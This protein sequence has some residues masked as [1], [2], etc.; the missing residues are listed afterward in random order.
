MSLQARVVWSEGMHLSQHHFQAQSRYFESLV[1]FTVSS[2]FYRPVGLASVELDAD[3]LTNG[4][5]ALLHARG[6]MPDGLTFHF[7][8]DPPPDPLELRDRFSPTRESHTILLAVRP[9][10]ARGANCELEDDGPRATRFSVLP[11]ALV[12]ETTGDDLRPVALARKNFSLVLDVELPEGMIALPVARVR[13]DGSGHVVYDPRFVPPCVRI[14]A[15]QRLMQLLA[16]LVERLEAKADAMLAE[17]ESRRLG[18]AEYASREI[19]E[20]WLS[21]TIHAALPALRQLHRSRSAHP[22]VLYEEL[23]RLAGALCTFALNSHPRSLPAYDHDDLSACFE[24][25]ERHIL[26]HLEVVLPSRGLSIPLE[27]ASAEA[28]ERSSALDAQSLEAY[29]DFLVQASPYFHLGAVADRR[30]FERAA[31]YLGVRSSAPPAEITARVP[32]LVKVCSAK[33]IARLVKDAYPGLPLE[34]VAVPPPG[35]SPRAGTQYFRIQTAGACW[36]SIVQ[37]G[38]VGVYAPASIPDVELALDVLPEA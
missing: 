26:D 37:T 9:H 14:S 12:D 19:V 20:F 35:I 5:V 10:Q 24:A 11:R 38:Q 18:L 34:H 32:S 36:T 25:L 21:H 7:P 28:L 1:G 17:R 22:E 8:D 29:R 16:R 33:H 13:R 15:S 30:S 2:L 27:Q 31:W 4:T 3:A 23:A 6:T